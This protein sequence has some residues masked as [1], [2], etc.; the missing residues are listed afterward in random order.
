[1]ICK[2]HRDD[3]L[4]TSNQFVLQFAITLIICLIPINAIYS[5]TL[6][7]NVLFAYALLILAFLIKV[8]IDENGQLNTSLLICIALTLA[9]TAHLSTYGIYIAI[10][11]LIVIIAYLFSK[12][13]SQKAIITLGTATIVV[14]LLIFSLNV[15]YDVHDSHENFIESNE[16]NLEKAKSDYFTSI[17]EKPTKEY[18]SATSVNYGNSKYNLLNPFVSATHKN[19]LLDI[20]FNNPIVYF[21]LAIILLAFIFIN[22]NSK[23]LFLIYVPS[24]LNMV[25]VFITS[26]SQISL[27]SNLLVCYLIIIILIG[28]LFKQKLNLT[29]ARHSQEES[30]VERPQRSTTLLK[31]NHIL[32]HL[33]RTHL[34]LKKN[35]SKFLKKN[36]LILLMENL[37]K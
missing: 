10:I 11:S 22:T 14:I 13:N 2:Y 1:M 35:T 34:L 9:F 5:I 33:I 37:K 29:D 24:F 36:P 31:K 15:I 25:I 32:K 19:I 12:G 8:L 4:T 16:I 21:V 18:E 27:Y 7:K 23:E 3:D 28:I 30:P 17:N 26:Q 20:L 6:Q